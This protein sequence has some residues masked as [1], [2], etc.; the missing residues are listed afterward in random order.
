MVI[1][2]S[3]DPTAKEWSSAGVAERVGDEQT[4]WLSEF[5]DKDWHAVVTNAQRGIFRP[6]GVLQPNPGSPNHI[7]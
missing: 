4:Y 1:F 6:W 7:F 2:G 3:E 5:I